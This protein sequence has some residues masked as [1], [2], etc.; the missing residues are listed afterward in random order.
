M[1]D[2]VSVELNEDPLDGVFVWLAVLL[3]VILVVFEGLTD[4][5]CVFE[6]LT[7]CVLE[8][9]LVLVGLTDGVRVWDGVS[10]E[11]NE[12][13]LDCVF[14]W[15]AVL[16]DVILAVFE[17]L[18]VGVFEGDVDLVGLIDGVRVWDGVLLDVIL[19]VFEGLTDVVRVGDCVLLDVILAVFEGLTDGV[20]EGELD[21]VG[22]IDGV[23]EG[24]TEPVV[25]VVKVVV[26]ILDFVTLNVGVVDKDDVE[27]LLKL[28]VCV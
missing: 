12:D 16:L 22:L 19:A 27:Y 24:V 3:D 5:V 2:G 21:L 14:V 23:F 25:V 15:L 18:N 17:G 9:D 28:L 6:G 7:D 13:P 26:G 4:G 8:G 1:R 20:I 11:L 10:V